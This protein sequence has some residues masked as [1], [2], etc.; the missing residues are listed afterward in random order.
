[1]HTLARSTDSA[2]ERNGWR[3]RINSTGG[4]APT[5]DSIMGPGWPMNLLPLG[6]TRSRNAPHLELNN[7]SFNS[8][9][10]RKPAHQYNPTLDGDTA[11]P[12]RPLR[13]TRPP[14]RS[15]RH[16][17]PAGRACG[18]RIFCASTR[19]RRQRPPKGTLRRLLDASNTLG[20]SR[21]VVMCQWFERRRFRI[22]VLRRPLRC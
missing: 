13:R 5:R 8:P 22:C 17:R 1:V 15:V 10:S 16:P 6:P 2:S 21:Q 11:S 4:Q 20:L 9:N 7:V 18:R 14:L 3:S 12:R 19:S